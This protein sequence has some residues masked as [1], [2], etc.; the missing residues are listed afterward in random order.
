MSRARNKRWGLVR[1]ISGNIGILG[2]LVIIIEGLASYALLAHDIIT[3]HSLAE[4]RHTQYDPELGWVNKPSVYIPNMYGPGVYFKTNSQ[5]FRNSHDFDKVVPNGKHRIVCSGDSFTLGYGVDN[6]H[7]WCH[8]LTTL[9][10]RL[11]TLNMGQG[12]YGVDQAYLWYKRDASTFEYQIHLMAFITAD[13]LRMQKDRFLGYG[14]PLLDIENGR[15]VVKNVPVPRRAYTFSW[16]TSNTENLRSLREVELLERVSRK[17]GFAPGDTDPLLKKKTNEKTRDV[18]GKIFEDL[19][20]LNEEHSSKLALVYLPTLDEIKGNDPQ[21]WMIFIKMESSAL[22]IPLIN[23]LST[24]RSLP[25]EDVVNMF[26]PK[27]QID[28]PAA[29]GHLNNQGNEFVANVIHDKLK[30]AL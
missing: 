25:Y 27:G 8:L 16:L 15:L 14:K 28:F 6:D 29:A 26:I 22:G 5:G 10:P 7:T 11:E 18:L 30:E 24:F 19:K 9:D 17:I 12:G 23:V 3:T 20:R 1:L 4:R 21:E 13:F 2:L